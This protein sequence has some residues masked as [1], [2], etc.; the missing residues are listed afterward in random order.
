MPANCISR[1]LLFASVYAVWEALAKSVPDQG[2]LGKLAVRGMQHNEEM[3]VVAFLWLLSTIR[4]CVQRCALI[5]CHR[6]RLVFTGRLSLRLLMESVVSDSLDSLISL[7]AAVV[8]AALVA[9][10]GSCSLI[11]TDVRL[12]MCE[13]ARV[14]CSWNARPNL[15]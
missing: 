11:C 14:C 5:S 12:E 6:Q 15:P 10:R 2:A 7:I 9:V 8:E 3:G 13:Q 1:L 4:R